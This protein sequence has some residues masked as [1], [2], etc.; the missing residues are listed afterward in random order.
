[1]LPRENVVK[2][3]LAWQITQDHA[4]SWRGL[5]LTTQAQRPGPRE[6]WIATGARWPGSLQRMVRPLCAHVVES[7]GGETLG[8]CVGFGGSDGKSGLAFI[9]FADITA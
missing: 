7:V 4:A 6:A 9:Q 1:M 2:N 5:G 3:D 8:I